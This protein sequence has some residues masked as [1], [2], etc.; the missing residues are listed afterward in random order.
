MND[1]NKNNQTD[2]NLHKN[3]ED[4]NHKTSQLQLPSFIMATRLK[5]K[6]LEN[7]NK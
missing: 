7:N 2:N 3:M 1:V 5:W 4:N 6:L